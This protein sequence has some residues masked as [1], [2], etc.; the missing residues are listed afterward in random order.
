MASTRSCLTTTAGL[1]VAG[2]GLLCVA[3]CNANSQGAVAPT[4]AETMPAMAATDDESL[5]TAGAKLWSQNCIRCHNI[6]TPASY[7]DRQWQIV[8]HHMRVRA[9]LTADEHHAILKFLEAA[10]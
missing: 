5:T 10:N 2:S 6:R 3:G 1:A 4:A 7:S 9:N 8:M